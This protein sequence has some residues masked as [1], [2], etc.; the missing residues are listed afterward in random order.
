[1]SIY[2]PNIDDPLAILCLLFKNSYPV[3]YQIP[4]C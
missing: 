4:K 1:M 2:I 3:I